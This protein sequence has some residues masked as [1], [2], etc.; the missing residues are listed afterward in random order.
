MSN[1]VVFLVGWLQ[2]ERVEMLAVDTQTP[3]PVIHAWVFTDRPYFGGKHPVLISGQAALHTLE[4]A[5]QS[6]PQAG[7]P[8]VVV[9]GQLVSHQETSSV[10]ARFIRF[11]GAIDPAIQDLL[12]GLARM[13]EQKGDNQLRQ[14]VLQ[15]LR[16]NHD[17][18][19][20]YQLAAMSLPQA[21]EAAV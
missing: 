16:H 5:R 4:W 12:L 8:Q 10:L 9:Q 21:G 7:L 14:D 13:V 1:N 2:V 6:D 15:L 11:L 3:Q 18:A 17:L 20:A 19:E